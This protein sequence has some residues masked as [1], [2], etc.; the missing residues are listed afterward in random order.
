MSYFCVNCASAKALREQIAA[1]NG[2]VER[3]QYL[4]G[5]KLSPSHIADVEERIRYGKKEL[6][7]HIVRHTHGPQDNE[8]V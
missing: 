8:Q 6:A 5:E 4:D 7:K 2:L 3:G 1:L